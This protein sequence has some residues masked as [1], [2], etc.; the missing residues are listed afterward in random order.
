MSTLLEL[1]YI[2]EN[3]LSPVYEILRIWSINGENH[4]LIP[5]NP[6][7]PILAFYSITKIESLK[8][9]HMCKCYYS[10]VKLHGQVIA[11]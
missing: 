5:L 1:M 6:N 10:S 7:D 3:A 11:F 8:L 4:H 9:L 2:C